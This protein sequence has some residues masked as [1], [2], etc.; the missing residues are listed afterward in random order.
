MRERCDDRLLSAFLD[1]E[2]SEDE[3]LDVARHVAGCPA[4]AKEL[5]QLRRMRNTLR[6][7][8]VMTAP[9]DMLDTVARRAYE[10]TSR[11]NWSRR[12]VASAA[13]LSLVG[14]VAWVAGGQG[15][16]GSV[17]PPMERYVVDHVGRVGGGPMVT[18]V[19][20]PGQ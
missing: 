7:L 8:P 6:D 11:A 2:L 9:P 10:E 12:A 14:A 20:L 15:Q 19:D 18:P 3:G 13:A 16:D 1:D 17:V 4:C 5:E